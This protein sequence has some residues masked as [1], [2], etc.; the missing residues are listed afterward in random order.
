MTNLE[1]A[2]RQM[3]KENEVKRKRQQ[4]RNMPIGAESKRRYVLEDS[5]GGQHDTVSL[6]T[7]G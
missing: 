5:H 7:A 3:L 6:G 4:E 2:E 1:Y